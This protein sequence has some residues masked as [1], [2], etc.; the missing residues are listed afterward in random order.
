[1]R[2]RTPSLLLRDTPSRPLAGAAVALALVAATT[3]AIY[4]LRKVVPQVSTGVLYL[5]AVLVVSIGWGL[6][7]GLASALASAAAWNWFHIPPTGRFS[8]HDGENWVALAVFLVAAVMAGSVAELARAQA[9]EAELRRREADL[10]AEIARLL[11]GGSDLQ[12]ALGPAAQ[13]VAAALGLRSA[14]IE[15]RVVAGDERRTAL[16]LTHD[17]RRIGTLLLPASELDD[18]KRARVEERA[19]PAVEALLGVALQRAELEAEAVETRALRRSDEIKTAVLRAVSHDLRSPLTAIIATNEALGS[20]SLG[21]DERSELA[22]ASTTEAERLARLVDKLLDL[23]RLQS[24]RAEPR[25]DWVSLDE[26]LGTAVDARA[27]AGRFAVSIDRDPPLVRADAAQLDRAVANLL[28]NAARYSGDLPVS[29]R[30]RAVGHRILVRIVDRGPGIDGSE[31]ERIFEP[32]HRVGGDDVHHT[33]S[34]LGLAIARGFIEAN[35]G[36][37]WAESLPGQGAAFVIEL[38][39]ESEATA[40]RL[41]AEAVR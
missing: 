6:R 29:V 10:A 24:G 39:L 12:Q 31:L 32:F 28:E 35:G 1:M 8:I 5:V 22:A 25:R 7:L 34:G 18:D 15:L 41:P 14:A 20:S 13:R 4:P 16:P 40:P 36:R 33:G 9:T 38:P 30:A 21:A 2:D 19:L 37:V 26:L 23:S 17:G 27:D 11:L 3:L